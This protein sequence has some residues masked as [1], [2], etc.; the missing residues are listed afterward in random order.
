MLDNRNILSHSSGCALQPFHQFF[1]SLWTFSSILMSFLQCGDN[2]QGGTT[3]FLNI[4]GQSHLLTG[5]N[6]FWPLGWLLVVNYW[7]MAFCQSASLDPFLQRCPPA[8]C[9]LVC[10]YARHYFTPDAE[11]CNHLCWISCNLWLSNA[12]MYLDPFTRPF[13]LQELVGPPSLVSSADFL[14]THYNPPSRYLIKI[15]NYTGPRVE[16]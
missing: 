5:K 9:L 10:T 7:F 16:P 13:I 15:L 12:V 14:N 8:T 4:E 1:C 2:C 6:T 11:A 3:S